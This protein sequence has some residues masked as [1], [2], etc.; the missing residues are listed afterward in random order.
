MS[1]IK[2]EIQTESEEDTKIEFKRKKRTHF[3]SRVKQE[4]DEQDEELR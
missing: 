4:D 2:S 1:A 3:R